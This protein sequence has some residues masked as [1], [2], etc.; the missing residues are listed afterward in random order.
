MTEDQR[1]FAK[2]LYVWLNVN[3]YMPDFLSENFDRLPYHT[4][5]LV[6]RFING[7]SEVFNTAS[8]VQELGTPLIEVHELD[9]TYEIDFV[10]HSAYLYLDQCSEDSFHKAEPSELPQILKPLKLKHFCRGATAIWYFTECPDS[11]Q[12]LADL[13]D[14]SKIGDFFGSNSIGSY[15]E[16]SYG[17]WN[18]FKVDS[19][20]EKLSDK[21][22]AL[23]EDLLLQLTDFLRSVKV[24]RWFEMATIINYTGNYTQLLNNVR[25][26]GFIWRHESVPESTI[27]QNFKSQREKFFGWW[28]FILERTTLWRAD[29]GYDI[30]MDEPPSPRTDALARRM[31]QIAE[32]WGSISFANDRGEI[33]K[34]DRYTNRNTEEFVCVHCSR[35]MCK[36]KYQKHLRYA[37][38]FISKPHRENM[39]KEAW[40]KKRG[41][42]IGLS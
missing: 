11:L 4:I 20:P 29:R 8:L 38:K 13:K 35:A 6:F 36:S 24:L 15:F 7:G 42:Q 22:I 41:S 30:P 33:A 32:R 28:E 23:A 19:F 10:H 17:L 31:T 12:Q 9:S 26:I 3:D 18:A 25:E 27:F 40:L 2:Y 16:M 37:C 34:D 14:T 5:Q 1:I 39:R 21:E